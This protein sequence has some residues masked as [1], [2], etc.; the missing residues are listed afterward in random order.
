MA[1]LYGIFFKLNV[2]YFFCK[3]LWQ[4]FWSPTSELS[5]S[6]PYLYEIIFWKYL[7]NLWDYIHNFNRPQ[8]NYKNFRHNKK[9]AKFP[10]VELLVFLIKGF[11]VFTPLEVLK[12]TRLVNITW[13]KRKKKLASVWVC[14]SIAVWKLKFFVFLWN[15]LS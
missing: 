14:F 5:I 6:F 1:D 4:S 2:V 15:Y 7:F 13:K 9:F 12:S 10:A 11:Q 3:S 8:R